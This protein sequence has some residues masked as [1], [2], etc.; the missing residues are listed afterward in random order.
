[1]NFVLNMLKQTVLYIKEQKRSLNWNH[2]IHALRNI[3]SYLKSFKTF[4]Y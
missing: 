4:H 1:M 3:V 2:F